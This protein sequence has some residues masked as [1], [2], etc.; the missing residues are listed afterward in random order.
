MSKK[1]NKTSGKIRKSRIVESTKETRQAFQQGN[2]DKA[3]ITLTS[4]QAKRDIPDDRRKATLAEAY[5]R[6]AMRYRTSS[7]TAVDDL[8]NAVKLMPED[9]CYVYHL[10]LLYHDS[11]GMERALTYYRQVLTLDPTF[12][13][14][15]L[16]LILLLQ[17]Q[18]ASLDELKGEAAWGLLSA[19]QQAAIS[20][21][22]PQDAKGLLVGLQALHEGDTEKAEKQFR[23]VT[24]GKR[25]PK[26]E[27]A[28]AYDYLGRFA[29]AQ[30]DL[31][32]ALRHW[33]TARNLGRDD[34]T[35]LKNLTNAYLLQL[36]TL[37]TAGQHKEALKLVEEAQAL[38][39][40]HPRI[41]EIAAHTL[42][43]S[44]YEA[45][46]GGN[47][48]LALDQWQRIERA[49]GATARALAANIAIAHEK[50]EYYEEAADA[51]RD[52]V[53]RRGRKPGQDN[54]LT[55]EQVGRLWSHISRLYAQS[56]AFDEAVKTLKTALKHDPD[57]VEMNLQLARRLAE[58]EQLDA[59]QNQVERVLQK[60]PNHIE[61]LVFKAE[62]DE[63]TPGIWSFGG[64]AGAEAWKRVLE[65]GDE[66]Y[67]SLAR[68]RL[69]LLYLERMQRLIMFMP[70]T[71]LKIGEEALELLPDENLIRALYI[72][73]LRMLHKPAE[74]IQTQIDRVDLTDEMA[75]HQLIDQ[76]HIY[77]DD[78][79]AE[80][81]QLIRRAN[82]QKQ[83]SGDFY[84][85]V[86]ACA[87]GREQLDVADG[88]YQQALDLLEDPTEKRRARVEQAHQYYTNDFDDEAIEILESVLEEDQDFGPAHVGMAGMIMKRE[89]DERKAKQ[90][91]RKA[92]RWARRH[93][94][95]LTAQQAKYMRQS[96]DNPMHSL[97]PGALG[98][99]DVE[100]LPPEIRQ[101]VENMSPA[102]IRALVQEMLGGSDMDDD[103]LY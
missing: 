50:L 22:L 49:D 35:F 91:L 66:D 72:E 73:V 34:D 87:V 96:I 47:W 45:A 43:I 75:L 65:V 4:T 64:P 62:L 94:D 42:L 68:Q 17:G 55:P 28:I 82:E 38:R 52:F 69:R 12:E 20:G 92:E 24:K 86:A 77:N 2:Y 61:A 81:E 33:G 1:R 27:Q 79:G 102:E 88:Y 63:V 97:F 41:D 18:G 83:L 5:F 80:A 19:E 26:A 40:E 76:A 7:A 44:G 84:K 78:D 8:E 70:E 16:P 37:A 23:E 25:T 58:N 31:S 6:R 71:A 15:A 59:A 56:G 30:D 29:A 9:A 100:A 98:G 48:D 36:E 3:I 46:Q 14:V 74:T 85:G 51:W 11:N 39:L 32:S 54:Y 53:K 99:L 67:A 10:G 13:R 103:E 90:H 21:S 57:N 89:N 93:N 60:Q 101:I 95:Q